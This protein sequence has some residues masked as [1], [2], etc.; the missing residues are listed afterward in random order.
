VLEGYEAANRD[1]SIVGRQ[2]TIEHFFI[3]RPD[4]FP[5][6]KALG[7]VIS[8]QDHLYLAA[9][10]MRE[11]WGKARADQVTPVRT[12]LDQGFLVAAGTDASVVPYNPFWTMYHFITRDTISDGVY[13]A[14]QKITREEALRMYTINNARMTFEDRDKGSIE[15]GKLADLVVL[16]ADYLTVPEKQIESL[17][18]LM[19]MVGGRIVYR[20]PAAAF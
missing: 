17:K 15:K 20:D 6:A 7:V 13:G 19:T 9:P 3:A 1:R 11:Y 4:H 8:A 10:S 14:N 18:P 2:W 16:S 5:R 12:F